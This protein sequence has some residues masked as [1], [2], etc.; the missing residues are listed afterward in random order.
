MRT[1]R[2]KDPDDIA[3]LL[4]AILITQLALAEV[5][6][7]NIRAVVG[8][9]MNHVTTVFRQLGIKNSGK[10]KGVA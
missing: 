6:Q 10:K 3:E 2:Q 9:D 7:R 1:R 4:R 5:P 8:C